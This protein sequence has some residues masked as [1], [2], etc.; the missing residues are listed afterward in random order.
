MKKDNNMTAVTIHKPFEMK[1]MSLCG[2]LR[3]I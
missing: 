1:G 3:R 2:K